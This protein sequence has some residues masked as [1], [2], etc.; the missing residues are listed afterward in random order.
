[1]TKVPVVVLN[2]NTCVVAVQRNVRDFSLSAMGI[3]NLPLDRVWL[4]EETP[5]GVAR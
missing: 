4:E 5:P 2:H 3:G 1:M